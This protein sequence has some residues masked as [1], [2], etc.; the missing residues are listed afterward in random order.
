MWAAGSRCRCRL[1]RRLAR[2]YVPSTTE[3]IHRPPPVSTAREPVE[4]R[5]TSS[6]S[7]FSVM[8]EENF[9]L[10]DK[11]AQLERIISSHQKVMLCRPPKFGKTLTVTTLASLFRG[12]KHLFDGTASPDHRPLNIAETAWDW[13]A[14]TH[15]VLHFDMAGIAR[16]T[17]FRANL[18]DV[19][20]RL[21]RHMGL[22]D[23]VNAA[24]VK[25]AT[26]DLIEGAARLSPSGKVVV[27][28][29]EVDAPV[30]SALRP[31]SDAER[32]VA[33]ASNQR[34][35]SDFLEAIDAQESL[36]RFQFYTG[37]GLAGYTIQEVHENFQKA[38]YALQHR[39]K[40]ADELDQHIIDWYGGYAWGDVPE[41]RRLLNPFAVN[42]LLVRQDFGPHWSS[43]VGSHMWVYDALRGCD[44][45]DIF[46]GRIPL[47][48]NAMSPWNLQ[49]QGRG[50]VNDIRNLLLR[51]GLL[52]VKEVELDPKSLMRIGTLGVPNLDVHDYSVRPLI[53]ALY[54]PSAD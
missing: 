25:G 52:T 38:R 42:Q 30:G 48:S 54:L 39:L 29:D 23:T 2:R 45:P 3:Q 14:E 51:L 15:N 46:E 50:D 20:G 11:T 27:L 37:V 22:G 41:A 49:A 9:A 21:G 17:G 43:A 7:T 33:L 34:V 36:I 40:I 19:M 16:R 35:L 12:H 24:S 13:H 18:I 47:Q 28:I 44:I 8:R 32:K 26:R 5:I 1:A 10:V 4:R 53:D 31:L 6:V